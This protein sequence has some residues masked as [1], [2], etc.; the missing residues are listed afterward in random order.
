VV[1]ALPAG[2][3]NIGDVDVLTLPAIP[4]GTN[5]IGDVDVASIAAGDNNIGNVD[6]V[7]LPAIPA[8]NN[9]IGDVDVASVVPGTG[10]T[11]LGKA[12]DAP[13]TTG[14]VG[15]MALG[16]NNDGG[17]NTLTSDLGDYSPIATDYNGR[18]LVATGDNELV[19]TSD[20]SLDVTLSASEKPEDF[21]HGSGD[22]GIMALAVRN[23]A[24]AARTDTTGDYSPVS[25][26]SL[27]RV[28]TNTVPIGTEVT[29][30][31]QYTS[32]QTGVALWTPTAGNRIVVQYI[33]IQVGGTTGGEVQVWFGASADTTYT[34][35]TDRAIFDGEFA[36]S[37]TLKPGFTSTN[38]TGWRASTDDHILRVT[39]SAAINPITISV[40]GY[41]VA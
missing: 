13:H 14:D 17:S 35:G 5:N 40:W 41:E 27:G 26:D 2:T 22:T 32:Q 15:V 20:G 29:K 16:V 7:T 31:A 38:E 33:Q 34:R 21:P 1:A 19:I 4:A 23:D 25:T 36:P 10:A 11:N 12:E 24:L 3:N 37:A 30:T 9:N 39:T 8:G 28:L 18:V 6:V